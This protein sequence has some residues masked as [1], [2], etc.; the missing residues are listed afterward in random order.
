[1]RR[2]V[3]LAGLS[4]SGIGARKIR[5]IGP[6]IYNN[7]DLQHSSSDANAGQAATRAQAEERYSELLY[8]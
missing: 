4:C 1:M 5:E 8:Q 7:I 6:S 3:D 2:G